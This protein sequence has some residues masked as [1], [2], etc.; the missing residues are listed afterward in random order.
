MQT[1]ASASRSNRA[2]A[3]DDA[4]VA[5]ATTKPPGLR[6]RR[7]RQSSR[8]G[9]SRRRRTAQPVGD[10]A[11]RH[12]RSATV[13]AAV[14]APPRVTPAATDRPRMRAALS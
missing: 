3:A 12:P 13:R 11:E 7:K 2:A 14:T 10:V 8:A 4:A 6:S 5:H 9:S 1:Q